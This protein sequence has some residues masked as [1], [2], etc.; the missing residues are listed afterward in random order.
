[1][2]FG[3]L[4]HP[5][6]NDGV[7]VN[8]DVLALVCRCIVVRFDLVSLNMRRI[9]LILIYVGTFLMSQGFKKRRDKNAY[10]SF[11]WAE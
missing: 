8:D 7:S 1:V 6:D 2:S 10:R 11:T 5:W 9:L 4:Q 3:G